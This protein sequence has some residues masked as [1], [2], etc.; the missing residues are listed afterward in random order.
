M[1]FII[2]LIIFSFE[3][4]AKLS[5]Y[6]YGLAVGGGYI[7]DYPA[8]DQGR[9]RTVYFPSFR[10]RGDLFRS[11]DKGTRAMFFSSEDLDIDLSF[12]ASFPANSEDNKAR[13]GMNDLNWL[14]ELGPRINYT[15]FKQ[16]KHS[17]E[18]EIP[19]RL[20]FET[21]FEFT[22]EQ[23]YRFVPQIDYK[24]YF[25][26]KY[27][28]NLSFKTV[29]ATEKL[30]DYFYE[31]GSSDVT[32]NRERFNSKGGHLSYDTSAFLLYEGEKVFYLGGLRISNYA[33]SVNNESPLYRVN[34][35]TAV[36]FAINYFFYQSK[37]LEK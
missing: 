34:Q 24:Y 9:I 23:G 8:A 22:K 3:A 15:I 20:V 31:V 12:G 26:T 21:D 19:I 29:W 33:N 37:N 11:D 27:I 5:L 6:E 32:E 36:F 7:S 35:D 28:L 17:L 25:T 2:L 14:A 10:Y 4:K 18:L 16:N 1:I 13:K 30:N